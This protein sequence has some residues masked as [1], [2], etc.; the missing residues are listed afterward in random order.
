MI[1][2]R[3]YSLSRRQAYRYLAEAQ[4]MPWPAPMAEPSIAVTFKLP[5]S[6]VRDLRAYAA[7]SGLTQGEIVAQAISRFL[8]QER[9]HG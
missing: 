2:V 5:A 9:K 3:D 4:A 8:A 7:A 1:L 6:A